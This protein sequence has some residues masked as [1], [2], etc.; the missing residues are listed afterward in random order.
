M[1]AVLSPDEAAFR[2]LAQTPSGT[3]VEL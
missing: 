3:L 2:P 1:Y